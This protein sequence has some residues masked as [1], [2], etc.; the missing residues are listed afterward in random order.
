[1]YRLAISPAWWLG[2]T[3]EVELEAGTQFLL[4]AATLA[5]GIR[6]GCATAQSRECARA[7][8]PPADAAFIDMKRVRPLEAFLLAPPGRNT[9]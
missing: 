4:L 6:I 8:T 2:G 3:Y 7:L 1:M 5:T 9:I